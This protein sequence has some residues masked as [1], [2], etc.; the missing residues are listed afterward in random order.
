MDVRRLITAC[1]IIVGFG[2]LGCGNRDTFHRAP[3]GKTS[4]SGWEEFTYD[5]GSISRRDRYVNGTITKSELFRPDGSL[6][7]CLCFDKG[8][9]LDVRLYE[10][11][12]PKAFIPFAGGKPHGWAVYFREDSYIKKAKLYKNGSLLQ[13]VEYS[14]SKKISVDEPSPPLSAPFLDVDRIEYFWET[15]APAGAR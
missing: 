7:A 11:G 2:V 14:V 8:N 6:Y 9:G 15:K 12:N 10:N 1:L 4:G 5:D 13:E 3:S